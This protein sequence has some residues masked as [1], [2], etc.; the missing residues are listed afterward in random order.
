VGAE[1]LAECFAVLL[2]VCLLV[3]A[4]CYH[5]FIVV[6]NPFV[7]R[8]SCNLFLT[9]VAVTETLT[10]LWKKFPLLTSEVCREFP[11][12]LANC[13]ELV[14]SDRKGITDMRAGYIVLLRHDK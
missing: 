2:L 8:L 13:C 4:E 3:G 14:H 5:E 7:H 11:V 12:P 9:L 6:L 1:R 10:L